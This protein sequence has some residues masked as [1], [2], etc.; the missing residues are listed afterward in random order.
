MLRPCF[1][2]QCHAPLGPWRTAPPETGLISRTPCR[3]SAPIAAA[4]ALRLSDGRMSWNARIRVHALAA[5]HHGD[6]WSDI[7][8]LPCRYADTLSRKAPGSDR[9]SNQNTSI[10]IA[11]G[12]H[13]INE[14]HCEIRQSLYCNDLSRNGAA[15]G[16]RSARLTPSPP[17]RNTIDETS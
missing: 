7:P 15:S 11:N 4:G 2:D 10:T 16:H 12:E 14:I 13:S 1:F 9:N 5:S 17:I 8:H 6:P 3:G